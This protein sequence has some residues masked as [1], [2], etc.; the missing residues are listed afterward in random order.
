MWLDLLTNDFVDALNRL[1]PKRRGKASIAYLDTQISLIDGEAIIAVNGAI[2]NCPGTG[3]WRGFVCVSYGFLLPFIKV[4]PTTERLRLEFEGGKLK[5]ETAKITAHWSETSPWV[6]HQL[7]EGY[8][9]K[10]SPDMTN[11]RFCS[12]CGKHKGID[13]QDVQN[14][15]RPTPA[16]KTLI[17]LYKTTKATHGCMDCGHGWIE[18]TLI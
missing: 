2:T 12:A 13:L 3:D 14:R 7:A 10:L 4:K 8:V 16:E 11:Y 18:I 6:M 1:K 9:K 5:I 15:T 17:D